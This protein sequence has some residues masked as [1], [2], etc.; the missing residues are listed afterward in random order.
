MLEWISFLNARIKKRGWDKAT[1]RMMGTSSEDDLMK[2]ID[3]IIDAMDEDTYYPFASPEEWYDFVDYYYEQEEKTA[4]AR[5]IR[6]AEP[7]S[8]DR[9]PTK[10]ASGAWQ[11][12]RQSLLDKKEIPLSSILQMERSAQEILNLLE[13][14]DKKDE[15][16]KYIH[17]PVWGLVMGN[18]QSGKTANMEALM[19][20]TAEFGWNVYIILT[21]TIENLRVQTE[22][23][24][25]ADLPNRGLGWQFLHNLTF[26]GADAPSN[27]KLRLGDSDRYV[28][29]CLK[30]SS[31]LK[32]LLR[33]L[34]YD[35]SRKAQMRVLVI[36][37]ESDQASLNTKKMDM[38]DGMTAD[39]AEAAAVE[40]TR[41]NQEIMAIV[42]G[43]TRVD[44]KEKVPYKAMNYVC[45]T[46]T[47]YGNF[48]NESFE[49][50][51]YP[52]N[53]RLFT[54]KCG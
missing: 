49:H 29:T 17:G 8:G 23:R 24:M 50:S 19:S 26:K 22:E 45:Y 18:V 41:I 6:A 34:N 4:T 15:N 33:W 35:K 37:D 30:N 51:L 40:R 48:L 7:G 10:R 28:I 13:D 53:F 16:G 20:M 5:I 47:P 39:E 3:T 27:L 31:R 21:G 38:L 46:A 36:D 9:I 2:K 1:A 43:N 44:S 42:N 54:Y 11:E 32:T 12:F 52:S 25:R 14:G